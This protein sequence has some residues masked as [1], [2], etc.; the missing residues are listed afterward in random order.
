MYLNV[1]SFDLRFVEVHV[2]YFCRT[3]D[4]LIFLNI[5]FPS[6]YPNCVFV[7]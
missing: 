5:D 6:M 7:I 4:S 3:N 1:P 2:T